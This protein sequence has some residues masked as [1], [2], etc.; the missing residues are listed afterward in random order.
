LTA[1]AQRIA[2]AHQKSGITEVSASGRDR[3]GAGRAPRGGNGRDAWSAGH[4]F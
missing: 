3:R 1:L 2:L 4:Y